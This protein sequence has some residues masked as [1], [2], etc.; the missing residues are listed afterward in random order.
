MTMNIDEL[1]NT[2]L[3]LTSHKLGLLS[4]EYFNHVKEIGEIISLNGLE[5]VEVDEVV[6]KY[7]EIKGHG[8][9]FWRLG[10][11]WFEDKPVMIIQNNGYHGF[12][13]VL[14]TI[15]DEVRYKKMI[16]YIL[17]FVDVQEVED[18]AEP[19]E[20]SANVSSFSGN[21]LEKLLSK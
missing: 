10:T 12:E 18:L 9:A 8:F 4:D 16:K 19:D 15:T 20:Y 14:R 2:D 3:P 17:R 5:E 11:V 1:Y 13:H 7:A 6:I 21:S